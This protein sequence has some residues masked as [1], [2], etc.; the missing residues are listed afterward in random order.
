MIGQTDLTSR[1]IH[2]VVMQT[3]EPVSRSESNERLVKIPNSTYAK[4]DL[5]QVSNNT[6]QMNADKR[7]QLLSLLQ[8]FKELFDVI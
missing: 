8:D 6:T 1:K 4:A 2:E 5:E 3:S 7:T